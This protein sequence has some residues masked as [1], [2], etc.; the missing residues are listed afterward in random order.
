[1]CPQEGLSTGLNL[2]ESSGEPSHNMQLLPRAQEDADPT[3]W[4]LGYPQ[5]LAPWAQQR[6]LEK[7]AQCGKETTFRGRPERMHSKALRLGMSK[8][9]LGAGPQDVLATV[10]IPRP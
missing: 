1:M 5:V 4:H 7:V 3:H 6:G 10:Q 9:D 8:L 2:A